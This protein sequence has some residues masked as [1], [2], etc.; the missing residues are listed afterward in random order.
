LSFNKYRKLLEEVSGKKLEFY[1]KKP[2]NMT[3]KIDNLNLFIKFLSHLGIRVTGV[4]AMGKQFYIYI[5]IDSRE[6]LF[7]QHRTDI[8]SCNENIMMAILLLII[9]N[10]H[11]LNSKYCRHIGG[12][13]IH[14]SFLESTF[15]RARLPSTGATLSMTSGQ[16]R[17]SLGVHRELKDGGKLS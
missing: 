13:N 3:K 6:H 4:S 11:N 1:V 2:D 10:D 17:K 7:D 12:I 16:N 15:A 14:H 8:Y 5:Y 9:K